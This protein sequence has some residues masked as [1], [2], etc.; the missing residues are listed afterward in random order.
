MSHHG[1]LVAVLIVDRPMCLDCI[2]TKA[3]LSTADTERYLESIATALHVQ[4]ADDRCRACGE[5]GVVFA[6]SRLEL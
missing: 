2:A 3:R 1:A 6:L 4:A 5:H